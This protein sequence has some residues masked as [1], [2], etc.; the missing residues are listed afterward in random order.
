MLRAL[1]ISAPRG[2]AIALGRAR[3]RITWDDLHA[4]VHPKLPS[5]YFFGRGHAPTTRDNRE[6]SSK[7]FPVHIRF[8]AERR[9][10]GLLL[11]DAVLPLGEDWS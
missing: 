6:Y 1:E 4:A 7:A 8:D 10:S 3:L 5:R 9:V 11:S 2:Q